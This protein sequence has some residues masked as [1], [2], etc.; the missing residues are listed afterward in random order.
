KKAKKLMLA[1]PTMIKR[2]VLEVG[3]RILVGFKPEVY[4]EAV[5]G[6]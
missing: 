4:E 3:D 6:K 1:K 2:P 5:G